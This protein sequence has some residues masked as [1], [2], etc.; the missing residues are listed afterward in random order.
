M[1]H[2]C[3]YD[4]L[5]LAGLISTVLYV[6]VQVHQLRHVYRHRAIWQAWSG[7]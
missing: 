5:L 7:E 2:F 6:L 3:G 1:R 4:L